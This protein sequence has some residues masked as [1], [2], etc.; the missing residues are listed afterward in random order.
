MS[1]FQEKMINSKRTK[2]NKNKQ[3][4]EPSKEQTKETDEQTKDQTKE[5]DSM[6]EV[7]L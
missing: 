5:T 3:T 4:N 6:T 7:F 1:L 2:T